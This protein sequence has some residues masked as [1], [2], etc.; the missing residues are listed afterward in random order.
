[1]RSIATTLSLLA[2]VLVS[3]ASSGSTARAQTSAAVSCVGDCDNDDNVAVDEVILLVQESLGVAGPEQCP[4]LGRV[5]AID[6]LVGSVSNAINGCVR[7]P[8]LVL[9][10]FPAELSAVLERATVDDVAP[11]NGK[12]FRIGSISG[13]PAI[14][15]MTGIGL[16]NAM[17]TTSAALE[18]FHVSGVIVSGVAGSSVLIGNVTVPDT[19]QLNDGESYP[20]HGR[21]IGIADD[22]RATGDVEL[23]KCTLRPSDP[24]QEVC[25]LGDPEIMVGGMGHS[26]DPFNNMA[27]PCIPD[28]T[29]VSACDV[30]LP[31]DPGTGQAIGLGAGTAEAVTQDMET[32]AIAMEAAAHGVP[33][34]AFRAVSDGAGDPLMLT[35]PFQQ[36]FVYYRL[37]ANNAA[38]TTEA[39]I[40]RFAPPAADAASQ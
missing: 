40:E 24:S 5:P 3:A 37:A 34:I 12:M 31:E 35:I 8:L 4:R 20:A 26:S 33:F 25:V 39:F 32:A 23:E 16:V 9:S 38:A 6:D 27:F 15:G 10:A 28:G 29:D 19:W 18:Q 2:A 7:R 1:M 13:V 36:F 30:P 21:W 17:N 14:M 22:V 11:V